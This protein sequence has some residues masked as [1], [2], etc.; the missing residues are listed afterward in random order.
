LPAAA[1]EWSPWDQPFEITPGVR[2]DEAVA[3]L[4]SFY[5]HT[6]PNA[7]VPKLK[8]KGPILPADS[9]APANPEH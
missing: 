5:E 9:A 4:Q 2:A 1:D 7:P 3:L 6:N 8:A